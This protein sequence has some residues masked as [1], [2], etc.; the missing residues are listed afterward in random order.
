MLYTAHVHQVQLIMSLQKKKKTGSVLFVRVLC[1]SSVRV[2]VCGG[3][4]CSGD[5]ELKK[6]KKN[7]LCLCEQHCALWTVT[8]C[9][10]SCL[11]LV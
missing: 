8:D 1:A 11:E 7:R 9:E 2:G 6:E 4:V 5:L 10:E 3:C